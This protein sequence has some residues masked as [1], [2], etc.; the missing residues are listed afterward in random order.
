MVK[1]SF[2]LGESDYVSIELEVTDQVRT[3]DKNTA[4]AIDRVYGLVQDKVAEK[5]QKFIDKV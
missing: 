4:A 3:T 5:A 2:K 1:T